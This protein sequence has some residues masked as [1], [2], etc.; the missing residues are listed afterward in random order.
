M[1]LHCN[2][3][4]FFKKNYF[5]KKRTELLAAI[6]NQKYKDFERIYKEIAEK[7]K[8]NAEFS[9]VD[10]KAINQIQHAYR[11]FCKELIE[12]CS[13]DIQKVYKVIYNSKK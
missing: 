4:T 6:Y 5:D 2:E 3:Q 13:N 7:I 12:T 9:E 8:N 10:Q 11:K 1:S